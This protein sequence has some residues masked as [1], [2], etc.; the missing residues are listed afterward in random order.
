MGTAVGTSVFNA[1]GWRAAAAL[2]LGW[3]GFCMLVLLARGPHCARYTWFGYEGGFEL[4]RHH[5]ERRAHVEE[6]LG[7]ADRNVHIRVDAPED[8]T[9]A[10]GLLPGGV[11]DER[12][13]GRE[14]SQGTTAQPECEEGKTEDNHDHR[15]GKTEVDVHLGG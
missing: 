8:E 12:G 2:N 10:L 9:R 6:G 5:G 11:P 3:E 14:A 13:C 7:A 4:R 15:E 1:H